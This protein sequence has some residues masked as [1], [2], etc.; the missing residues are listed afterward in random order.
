MNSSVEITRKRISE[1]DNSRTTL[2]LSINRELIETN[3]NPIRALVIYHAVEEARLKYNVGYSKGERDQLA[4]E[5]RFFFRNYGADIEPFQNVRPLVALG[6]GENLISKLNRHIPNLRTIYDFLAP[7]GIIY[8][9]SDKL[10]EEMKSYVK[11]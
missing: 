2:A 1:Y 11:P 7:S 4:E 6:R 5:V 10:V 9:T 3:Q 8:Q